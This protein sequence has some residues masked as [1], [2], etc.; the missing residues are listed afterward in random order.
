MEEQEEEQERKDKD[1]E[2]H[3]ARF[4][5]KPVPKERGRGGRRRSC[6]KLLL[7]PIPLIALLA[8]GKCDI[9]FYYPLRPWHPVPVPGCRVLFDSGYMLM[10]RY[11]RVLDYFTGFYVK[12][13]LTPEFHSPGNL[14]DAT[15]PFL[16]ARRFVSESLEEYR[17]WI[18]LVMA[19]VKCWCF[20]RFLLDSGYTL[21]YLVLLV[22]QRIRYMHCV[23]PRV[24]D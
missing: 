5:L 13:D 20:L 9:F 2:G 12:A 23:S 14:D 1:L 22:R 24:C 16:E 19:S 15:S 21:L 7:A 8:P 18:L 11:W 10:P 6:R 17:I 3:L 4:Q